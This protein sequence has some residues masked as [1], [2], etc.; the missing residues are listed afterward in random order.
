VKGAMPQKHILL[1]LTN[2]LPG[3]DDEFNEWYT[4]QHL[5]DLLAIPGV[6]AAQRYGLSELQRLPPPY[7]YAYCAIYEI[8]TDNLA[9]VLDALQ[10]RANTPAMP[11]S[12]AMAPNSLILYLEPIGERVQAKAE[13]IGK[14]P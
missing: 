14:Q 9:T 5:A 12:P 10:K 3:R 1:A 11:I 4:R 7:P 2:A 6:I 8:E 13:R